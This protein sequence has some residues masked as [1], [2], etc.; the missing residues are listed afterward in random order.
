MTD[1]RKT[2]QCRRNDGDHSIASPAASLARGT[3][4]LLIQ[5]LVTT[6]VG[7]AGFA[8]VARMLT[9]EEMGAVVGLV[10]VS[11]MAGQL[12]DLGLSSAVTKYVAESRGKGSGYSKFILTGLMSKAC[13]GILAGGIVLVSSQSLSLLLLR[14]AA[15]ADAFRLIGLDIMFA[16]LNA[17]LNSSLLG[18]ARIPVMVAL[19]I[20]SAVVRQT[21]A[22]VMVMSGWGLNGYVVGWLL[23][24][25]V[26]AVVG[27]L[28]LALGGHVKVSDATT[29]TKTFRQLLVF[30]WPLYV[31]GLVSY[32][33][34]MLDKIILLA[35]LSLAEAGVYNVANTAFGVIM[36]V[37]SAIGTVLFPFYAERTGSNEHETIRGGA[38]A[39]SRYVSLVYSPIGIGAAAVA[40][41]AISLLAGQSYEKGDVLLG[42][43]SLFSVL[44]CSGAALGGLM[45]SY[46]MTNYILLINLASILGGFASSIILAPWLGSLGIALARGITMAVSFLLTIAILRGKHGIELN[47]RAIIES[48]AAA[49]VMGVVVMLAQAIYYNRYLLP[50]YVAIGAVTY[51]VMLKLLGAVKRQDFELARE[52]LGARLSF[53]VDWAQALLL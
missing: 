14:S 9:V 32:A 15:Y 13:L 48:L 33:Y 51:F 25:L 26:Y 47:T 2:N 38:K 43:L 22:V 30:S 29:F 11:G 12:I 10:L 53:L 52:V 45:L 41:A 21:V 20:S 7:I 6:L 3:T 34:S 18:L 44:T 46:G 31:N 4:L 27:L 19:S 1:N 37:P 39:A 42:T 50:L 24:D 17:I 5:G 49:T 23:G 40:N 35:Y 16:V 8:F 28:Y 36:M